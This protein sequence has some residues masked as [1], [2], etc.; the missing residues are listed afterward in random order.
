MEKGKWGQRHIQ[1]EHIPSPFIRFP[2]RGIPDKNSR[3]PTKDSCNSSPPFLPNNEGF[4]P[5]QCECG[6]TED[7]IKKI[8]L[9]GE[10]KHIS[11]LY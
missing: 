9:N 8:E 3:A 6:A 1:V 7:Q 10:Y 2:S 5:A 11:K 4:E